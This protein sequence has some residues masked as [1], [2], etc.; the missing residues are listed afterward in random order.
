MDLRPNREQ[1]NPVNVFYDTPEI[2]TS[3][4]AVLELD[5][6]NNIPSE[7]ID[8]MVLD[9]P[10]SNF[11]LPDSQF[12]KDEV[13][14]K[15]DASARW[16]MSIIVSQMG[17]FSQRKHTDTTKKCFQNSVCQEIFQENDND[18]RMCS[19]TGEK[20]IPCHVCRK[21][22]QKDQFFIRHM[23]IHKGEKSFQ[24]DVRE[25]SRK[26]DLNRHLRIHSK[27]NLLV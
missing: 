8:L 17:H 7:I 12:L 15:S 18:G 13:L 1:E 20:S 4:E 10:P 27:E 26:G 14:D 3:S 2:A 16:Y 19:N 23:L 22:F 21:I 5:S 24:C 25:F 9:I 6:F 11:E